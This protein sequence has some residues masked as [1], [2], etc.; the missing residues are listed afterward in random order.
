MY[1]YETVFASLATS[2]MIV[3]DDVDLSYA[4]KMFCTRHSLLSY[5]LL[6]TRKVAGVARRTVSEPTAEPL[7]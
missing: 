5:Y 7:D 3:S 2:G 1:E 6:E 4:F